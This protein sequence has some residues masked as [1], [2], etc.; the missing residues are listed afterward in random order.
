MG[1]I[2]SFYLSKILTALIVMKSEGKLHRRGEEMG[3]GE[4]L[5]PQSVYP[6]LQFERCFHKEASPGLEEL[7]PSFP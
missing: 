7:G 5:F 1:R 2:T 3:R 6:G 4:E